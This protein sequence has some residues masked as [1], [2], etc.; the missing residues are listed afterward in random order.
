MTEKGLMM[1]EKKPIIVR[2]HLKA[3][4]AQAGPPLG[5]ALAKYKLAVQELC[6]NFNEQTKIYKKDMPVAVD[7]VITPAA[8]GFEY[9]LHVGTPTLTALIK[10]ELD[11]DPANGKFD[12]APGRDAPT[13]KLAK[14]KVRNIAKIKKLGGK[15]EEADIRTIEATLK[16]MNVQMV[17]DEA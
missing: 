16:S 4:S 1:N 13:R 15:D 7:I 17:N 12:K 11:M 3:Q 8:K 5:P 14:S 2:V 10:S 6:K 9:K